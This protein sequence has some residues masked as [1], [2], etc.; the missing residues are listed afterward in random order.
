MSNV[1]TGWTIG[2]TILVLLLSLS[3]VYTGSGPH[4]SAVT[5]QK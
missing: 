3:F 1:N 4:P 5:Q 2:V